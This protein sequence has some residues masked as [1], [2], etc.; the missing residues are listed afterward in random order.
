MILI[1]QGQLRKLIVI[2]YFSIFL[3]AITWD[4][5]VFRIEARKFPTAKIQLKHLKQNVSTIFSRHEYI[6]D[7]WRQWVLLVTPNT[8]VHGKQ[9]KQTK[10]IPSNKQKTTTTQK[11][12]N[13]NTQ[14]NNNQK[15]KQT[16]TLRTFLNT[17]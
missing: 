4:N 1:V 10:N 17:F 14:T 5:T 7:Q 8:Y 3:Q 12:N 6:N 11:S 15:S 9:N 2:R 16:K 13:K